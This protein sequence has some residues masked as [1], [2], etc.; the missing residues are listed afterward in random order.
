MKLIL[1]FALTLSSIS[2]MASFTEVECSGKLDDKS[3]MLEIEE[4][5][6]R[7]SI[8]REV[9]LHVTEDGSMTTH[10]YRIHY[11]RSWSIYRT[12]FSG[13]GI[14]FEFEHW[15]DYRPQWGRSYQNSRLVADKLGKEARNLTCQYLGMNF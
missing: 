14:N 10:R 12:I 4:P 1:A 9:R 6:P 15:P 3:F 8:L 5:F 11:T 7:G 2:A 13:P